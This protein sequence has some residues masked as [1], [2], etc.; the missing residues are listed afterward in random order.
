MGKRLNTQ[1]R[2]RLLEA[3]IQNEEDRHNP[4][5][6]Q[7]ITDLYYRLRSHE[8][9]RMGMRRRFGDREYYTYTREEL[10]DGMQA[11]VDEVAYPCL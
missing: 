1:T 8:L 5:V 10:L 4:Y 2:D 7:W 9:Y 11:V 6:S 3:A